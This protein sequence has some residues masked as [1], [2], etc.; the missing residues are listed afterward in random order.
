MPR[1]RRASR[2]GC[3]LT[4]LDDSVSAGSDAGFRRASNSAVV[5]NWIYQA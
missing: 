4:M 3:A 1:F 2:L 5:I